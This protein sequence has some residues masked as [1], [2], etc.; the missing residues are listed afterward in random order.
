MSL[1]PKILV[2]VST[3]KSVKNVALASLLLLFPAVG[4]SK[5]YES[6]F[7]ENMPKVTVSETDPQMLEWTKDDFNGMAYDTLAIPQPMIILAEKNKYKGIQP[8]QQKLFADRVQAIF[9]SRFG[10]FVDIV[11]DPQR[12][13]LVMNIA[14]TELM[15]K[16]KRSLLGFT[17][18]G[19]LVHAGTAN[20]KIEDMEKLAK[21]IEMKDANLE[22]E[23]IDG[24]TGELVAVRILQITG[25]ED[26]REEESWAA[27]RKEVTTVAE[28]F[29]TNYRAA[30]TKA[31][32]GQ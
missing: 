20:S 32:S 14:V 7:I 25:K 27:L 10:D 5:N 12:G 6:R 8:D 17:P 29:A 22:L 3:M 4:F 23:F 1:L 16:K 28:R 13:T 18:V 31:A 15:M 19:A 21:K 9:I 2:K 24:G 26:G 11:D 30:I